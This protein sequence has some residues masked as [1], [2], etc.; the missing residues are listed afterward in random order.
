MSD[1]HFAV[2]SVVFRLRRPFAALFCALILL[3]S[4][5]GQESV[6]VP[7]LIKYSGT[8][9]AAPA[10]T[11]GVMFALYKDQS[12]GAPL[13]QKVQNV[14]VDASGHFTAFLGASS[15]TGLPVDVFSNGEARWL[16]IQAD[17]QPDVQRHVVR[18]G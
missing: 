16:G 2:C 11:V 13:W 14:T 3:G 9:S 18:G 4:I 1:R 15:A 6:T 17:R 7:N 8:I 12:G 10:G 5:C